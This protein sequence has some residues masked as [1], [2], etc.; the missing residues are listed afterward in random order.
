[1][2]ELGGLLT[3][4]TAVGRGTRFS[5]QLPL[6]LT[7]VDALIVAVG[8]RTFAVPMASVREAI[9]IT[10][11]RLTALEQNE[12][13]AY[14]GGVLPLIRL[15]R[16]LGL[17]EPAAAARFALVVGSGL[18]AAGIAV[19]RIVDKR[20]IVVRTLADPLLQ[21]DGLAGA[22]EMGDGRPI[23]ILDAQALIRVGRP[24]RQ[25]TANGAELPDAQ[26]GTPRP[27]SNRSEQAMAETQQATESFVLCE[28][29]GAIYGI[30]SRLV[31]QI[32]MVEQITPVPNAP[33][34][35]AGIVF[36]RGQVIPAIDLRARFGFEKI[37][38]T[39]RSRLIVVGVG[40]RTIGLIV[41]TAREFVTIP[42]AAIQ[43]PPEAIAGLS[44]AYLKGLAQIGER[45]VVL[46]DLDEVIRS[47]E[48]VAPVHEDG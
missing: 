46:L 17:A 16:R 23:Q 27:R 12:L 48:T 9:E 7:I 10:P 39:L 30:P 29:A 15:A 44:G 6:T 1:V 37:A 2:Q 36:S 20:E 8:E 26:A 25:A 42:A 43:P 11:E 47:A 28:L 33:A 31:R 14:R 40:D 13:L 19:D 32:E 35:V 22:T 4:D 34:Y 24:H 41:D 18:G 5:I 45:L 21:V 3:L 38:Y